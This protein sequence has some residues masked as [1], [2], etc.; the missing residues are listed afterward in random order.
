M[1]GG[2]TPIHDESPWS[3]WWVSQGQR[4]APNA[5]FEVGIGDDE[6]LWVSF[7]SK[8]NSRFE[9]LPW[10]GSVIF[11]PKHDWIGIEKG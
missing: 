3:A 11:H 8:S 9:Y 2:A 4:E 6:S 10:E 5:P 7:G 1:V